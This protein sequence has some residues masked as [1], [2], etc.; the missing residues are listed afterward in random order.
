MFRPDMGVLQHQ[1]EACVRCPTHA[2]RTSAD[3]PNICSLGRDATL[4]NASAE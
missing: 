4:Q 2:T 3:L 1:A